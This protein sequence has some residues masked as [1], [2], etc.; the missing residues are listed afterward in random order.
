M[1]LELVQPVRSS[2]LRQFAPRIA[3]G[4]VALVLVVWP[5]ILYRTFLVYIA[6]LVLLYIIGAVSMHLILR[7]GLVSLGHAAFMG[8]GGYASALLVTTLHLSFP[9]AFAVSGMSAALLALLVGPIILRLRGVYFVLVT[10]TLGEIMRLVFTDWATLTGGSEGFSQIPAPWP[11]LMAI[12]N[13]YYLVLV[14]AILCV[15]FAARL[16]N[17]DIGKAIDAIRESESLAE[18]NGIQVFR[19]KVTVFT[20]AC[21]L[22]GLQGSLQAH[23]IHLISPLSYSFSESL[24]YVIFNVIGGL[25]TLWGPIIGAVFLVSLPELLRGWVEFQ[26]VFYGIAL[27]LVMAW[28]PGGLSEIGDRLLPLLRRKDSEETQ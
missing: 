27:I 24:N 4:I 10:F 17:S 11:A 6:T 16:L 25:N 7:M 5:F 12:R 13:Y 15:A 2:A 26:W 23:F 19:V 14:V 8:V 28:F 20:I 22:V 21:G 9:L 3:G 1:D 18:A